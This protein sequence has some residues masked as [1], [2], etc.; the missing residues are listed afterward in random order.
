[1]YEKEK[2]NYKSHNIVISKKCFIK[3]TF[4]DSFHNI[5]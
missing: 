3:V 4:S 2:V 1:M 5:E